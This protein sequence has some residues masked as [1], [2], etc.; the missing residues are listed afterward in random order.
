ML[1]DVAYGARFSGAD[2]SSEVR[3]RETQTTSIGGKK[4]GGTT[5]PPEGGNQIAT[6]KAA[7]ECS[8]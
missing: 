8:I 6:M 7:N 3:N 4:L 5:F 2:L 1:H